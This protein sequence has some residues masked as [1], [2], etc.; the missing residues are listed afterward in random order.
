MKIIEL[1]NILNKNMG[2]KTIQTENQEYLPKNNRIKCKQ[3]NN[4]NVNSNFS[5]VLTNPNNI[6]EF[7]IKT[8]EN[9]LLANFSKP[10]SLTFN[11]FN[12]I[13]N[14]KIKD[15]FILNQIKYIQ[16]LDDFIDNKI[17]GN[18]DFPYNGEDYKYIKIINNMNKSNI[19]ALQ[20]NQIK[21]AQSPNIKRNNNYFEK[22]NDIKNTII[23]SRPD[24]PADSKR[25]A[26]LNLS[27]FSTTIG[28][29]N[30]PKNSIY[31]NQNNKDK[32]R[33]IKQIKTF[34]IGK[35]ED[36]IMPIT[37]NNSCSDNENNKESIKYNQEQII[38][39][40]NQSKI[41][42]AESP[43]S[44]QTFKTA[45]SSSIFENSSGSLPS[46]KIIKLNYNNIIINNRKDTK[47]NRRSGLENI[48]YKKPL[49]PIN[50]SPLIKSPQNNERNKN[51]NKLI[52]VQ[53][54]INNNIIKNVKTIDAISLNKNKKIYT[55]L[56][57][58]DKPK[59]K[60]YIKPSQ[61]NSFIDRARSPIQIYSNLD[62]TF[63][64]PIVNEI[65]PFSDNEDES[66][67]HD[68]MNYSNLDLNP[69]PKIEKFIK[70]KN[71]NNNSYINQIKS[72]KKK[73]GKL[74]P[75]ENNFSNKNNNRCVTEEN[76]IN[77]NKKMNQNIGKSPTSIK[78]K[79]IIKKDI[80]A[81]KLSNNNKVKNDNINKNKLKKIKLN[82]NNKNNIINNNFNEKIDVQNM[83]YT[84]RMN[85]AQNSF[86]S[87]PKIISKSEISTNNLNDN[88]IIFNNK[89]ENLPIK[90][91]KIK[92][93][94]E[95]KANQITGEENMQNGD[96]PI[97]IFPN[98]ENSNKK[99]NK[100]NGDNKNMNENKIKKNKIDN[101]KTLNNE[102]KVVKEINNNKIIKNKLNNKIIN[103]GADDNNIKNNT[104]NKNNNL[105]NHDQ[106]A[107]YINNNTIT[108]NKIQNNVINKNINLNNNISDFMSTNKNLNIKNNDN[109]KNSYFNKIND[110]NKNIIINDN[111]NIEI[112]KN[113]NIN[114]IKTN[115]N[116]NLDIL[117]DSNSK[118]TKINK[119]KKKKPK[120]KMIFNIDLTEEDNNDDNH[121]EDISDKSISEE[122]KE[123]INDFENSETENLGQ[124]L[125]NRN[126]C[127]FGP[128]NFKENNLD[129]QENNNKNIDNNT[130]QKDSGENK[131]IEENEDLT[132]EL[133]VLKELRQ[134][135]KEKNEIKEKEKININ[136]NIIKDIN[137]NNEEN[138]KSNDLERI[139]N[140]HKNKQNENPIKKPNSE[141][142]QFY[143]D[144]DSST[145]NY[146]E[147]QNKENNKLNN[148]S[149]NKDMESNFN[150]NINLFQDKNNKNEEIN[151]NTKIDDT[152]SSYE[153]NFTFKR[154]ETGY[155]GSSGRTSNNNNNLI[156]QSF[157]KKEND[158]SEN[159]MSNYNKE[160]RNSSDNKEKENFL[161]F[162]FKINSDLPESEFNDINFLE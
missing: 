61:D 135:L 105:T 44:I 30:S 97:M 162:S 58:K 92:L 140:K 69:K 15:N 143:N 24:S 65:S 82:L 126:Y 75:F 145:S 50:A 78:K 90:K 67:I 114:N 8:E 18:L 80:V 52:I 4:V 71:N 96:E 33:N 113:P 21:R 93:E 137:I 129:I 153:K 115:I 132:L 101:N 154:N 121:S 158:N 83:N 122:N 138:Y 7:I 12:I 81:K 42:R 23:F 29:K 131:N 31:N 73:I 25:R 54:D 45:G 9:I 99:I 120:K 109:N 37:A 104:I 111:I 79:P 141:F 157:G 66:F 87:S 142:N 151:T 19:R 127:S 10:T 47:N 22:A 74:S 60:I 76:E 16:I 139:I 89:K 110:Y 149:I 5:Q 20:N 106:I 59:K 57:P 1:I 94:K 85:K 98:K 107:E 38:F 116:N 155:F 27:S 130:N 41:S 40:A 53:N 46:D 117:N 159:R 14:D 6:I 95:L 86:I 119:S 11:N 134:K 133:K 35:K 17:D 3:K 100:K 91:K 64:S 144:L 118:K 88:I 156:T 77:F 26:Q 39:N 2:N 13:H 124:S 161:K 108:N 123:K 32:N 103:N 147:K 36:F 146:N 128:K 62:K 84:D 102:I 68:K 160:E 70:N 34:K 150:L 125:L 51:K 43:T 148:N 72:K 152:N 112:N 49:S 28:G 48:S 55:K 136:N 56:V 63:F